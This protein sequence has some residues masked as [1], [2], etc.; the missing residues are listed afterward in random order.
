MCISDFPCFLFIFIFPQRH[1]N[2]SQSLCEIIRL[3][4]DQM[5]QV[6]GSSEPDPLLATLEKYVTHTNMYTQSDFNDVWRLTP[7][8]FLF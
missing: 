6:Q 1:S 3:S 7:V 2:A 5:F 8:L 4:R